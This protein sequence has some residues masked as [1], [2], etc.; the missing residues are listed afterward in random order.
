MSVPKIRTLQEWAVELERM[1]GPWVVPGADGVG[2]P[3]RTRH[4]STPKPLPLRGGE[5]FHPGSARLPPALAG[6]APELD[7]IDNTLADLRMG[8]CPGL[9]DGIAIWGPRGNGKTVLLNWAALSAGGRVKRGRRIAVIRVLAAQAKGATRGAL[10]AREQKRARSWSFNVGLSLPAALGG[11]F[12]V[13]GASAPASHSL[14]SDDLPVALK[15][16]LGRRRSALVL[17]DEAHTLDIDEGRELL[18]VL[19]EL[20]GEGK[21]G[22]PVGAIFAGT[23]DL[24]ERFAQ[25]EASFWDR[26]GHGATPLGRVSEGAAQQAVFAPFLAY[27]RRI[28]D[29]GAEADEMMLKVARHCAGYPYFA[30]ILGD[31]LRG[32]VVASS[33]PMTETLRASHLE[34][35]LPEFEKVKSRYYGYRL[36]ELR[37]SGLI[38]CALEVNAELKQGGGRLPRHALE[39]CVAKGLA[40][41]NSKEQESGGGSPPPATWLKDRGDAERKLLHVGYVFGDAG[42]ASKFLEPGI[43]TLMEHVEESAMP[44]IADPLPSV[45]SSGG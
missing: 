13:G 36:E 12:R 5:M 29:D 44:N 39:S 40:K 45:N 30:Q 10:R 7:K 31:E 17:V 41:R 33:D 38:E 35:A 3:Q 14:P 43:S 19:Q 6:R 42:L 28:A 18:N 15:R 22:R 20:R 26:I 34:A 9:A 11:G 32:A 37:K 4:P 21:D 2:R 8:K 23:P 1:A 24:P 25:M 27:G 16:C